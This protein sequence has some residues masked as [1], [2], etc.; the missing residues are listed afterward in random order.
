MNRDFFADVRSFP[1]IAGGIV[2]IRSVECAVAVEAA[3]CPIAFVAL[4]V[5]VLCFAFALWKFIKKITRVFGAVFK[6]ISSITV[7]AIATQAADLRRRF[8]ADKLAAAPLT[9]LRSAVIFVHRARA[10]GC[11]CAKIADVFIAVW[12]IRIEKEP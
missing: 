12:I 7:V 10:V 2:S 11:A 6:R 5:V 1:P 9:R 8:L 3:I 4:A